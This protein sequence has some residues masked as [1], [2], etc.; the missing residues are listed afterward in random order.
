MVVARTLY[1]KSG[2]VL[3]ASGVRLTTGYIA[4]LRELR[5]PAL[6][7]DD[8]LLEDYVLD[9]VVSEQTRMNA[10]RQVS[11]LVAEAERPASRQ[12]VVM[13]SKDMEKTVS[14]ILDELLSQTDLM[15]NLVDIRLE[16]DYLF[17]HSVNVC[18]LS[19]ITGVKRRLSR[20]RLVQLGLGSIL[21]DIGK[22]VIPRSILYKPGPLTG[23][24]YEIVKTHT[25]EGYGMLVDL[26]HA[27][28][29]AHEHHERYDGSGYPNKKKGS[30]TSISSQIAAIA[31]V[32]DAV[33]AD[34]VYRPAHSVSE[35]YEL[36][37]A[38]GNQG[39]EL[40]LIKD[41]LYNIAAYPAGTVVE[42]NDGRVAIC[43]DTRPGVSLLPRI[44]I[45]YDQEKRALQ[46][47]EEIDLSLQYTCMI[48]RVLEESE[49]TSLR[50]Q[51]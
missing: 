1:G 7:I 14:G 16:D 20:E 30:E 15:I 8:G 38:S 34:R 17:A 47:P 24:E 35:A 5:V 28:D 2:Q 19:L 12:I 42:L 37:A 45:L 3:L 21:H 18:I 33:S 4:Q 49:V 50:S 10:V 48:K 23:P 9:D 43:M 51:V 44:R 11:Q 39:F 22:V 27:R 26:L 46:V 29:I 41:F 32:F 40:Q 31:D 25:S 13:R 6:Y 36:L